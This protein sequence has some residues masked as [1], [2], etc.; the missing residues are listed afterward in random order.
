MTPYDNKPTQEGLYRTMGDC[1]EDHAA[2]HRLQRSWPHG[3]QRRTLYTRTLAEIPNIVGV[4]EASG[5]I[6]NMREY[7]TPFPST[8]WC[9]PAT[10][11]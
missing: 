10:T 5:N 3:L 1:L 9:F 8:S 11:R 6:Q 2:D 4:K 7:A